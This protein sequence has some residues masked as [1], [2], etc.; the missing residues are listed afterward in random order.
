MYIP[1]G[2]IGNLQ[3]EWIN[4]EWQIQNANQIDCQVLGLGINGHIGF[5]EPGTSLFSRTQVVDLDVSTRK[6]NARFFNSIDEVPEKAITMG[7][8]TIMESKE[9][10]LLIS[11]ES[12]A[13]AVAQLINGEVSS[14]FPAS[15]LK[16]HGRVTII[17]DKEALKEIEG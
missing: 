17:V 10:L 8:E 15:V 16:D 12:K 3:E 9:I 13:K 1:S 11:G 6:A 2:D 4:Y 5:N 7:I 14:N